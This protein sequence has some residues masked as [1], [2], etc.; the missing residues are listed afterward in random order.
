MGGAVDDSDDRARG[1]TGA[2]SSRFGIRVPPCAP[3]PVLVHCVARAEALGFGTA[4]VPDSQLLFRDA[5]MALA[6]SALGTEEIRLAIGV[7]NF[8]TRHP[9]V[10][11]AALQSLE[12]AAPGRAVLGVGSGDSSVKCLG[13]RPSRLAD[14]EEGVD[15]LR[16][17]SLGQTVTCGDRPARLRDATGRVPPF[18]VAATGPRTLEL[19]GRIA[20]GVL[21]M[22]GV[23]PSLVAQALGHVERGLRAAGRRRRDL[24]VCLGAVC[25]VADD[26]SDVVR[27]ATPHCVGDAQR[28]A[29]DAL[30]SAGVH[31]RGRV[32]DVIPGIEPDITHADD[33]DAA[34]AAGK[35]WVDDVAARRY[36]EAFTLIGTSD[37]LVDRVE[38]AIEAGVDSFYLRH[39]QSYRLPDDLID[40]FGQTVL[41]H[42]TAGH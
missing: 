27:I 33:W 26:E 40:R 23:T 7:T 4:W 31:L 20:D 28:G 21:V 22:A 30:E 15:E 41:P 25:H 13:W 8:R 24:E 35:Q 36:A 3:I 16:R 19:A 6:A 1:G 32:P 18:F 17:L 14:I 42:V 34:V 29:A 37:A 38:T 10:T 9:T 11:A 2:V 5:W 12:E 39:V